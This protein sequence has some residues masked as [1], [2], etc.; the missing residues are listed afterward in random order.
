M[1]VLFI[2]TRNAIRSPM[3]EAIAQEAFPALTVASAG[4]DPMDVDG[5]AI[6]VMAE[7]GLDLMRHEAQDFS[8]IADYDLVIALSEQATASALP[9]VGETLE[10]WSIADP[11]LVEG[12]RDQRLEAYRQVRE[13]LT[14]KIKARFAT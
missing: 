10:Q 11:S 6:A 3:A 14:T 13:T 5:F 9:L 12:N 2:C 1:R 7:V 8:Q 4:V